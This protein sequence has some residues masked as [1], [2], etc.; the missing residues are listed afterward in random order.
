[1][2]QFG[3]CIGIVWNTFRTNVKELLD[4]LGTVLR[5]RLS[6]LGILLGQFEDGLALVCVHYLDSVGTFLFG[7]SKSKPSS[8]NILRNNL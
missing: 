5:L 6:S 7:H 1:M 8:C 4:S 3:N 2:G